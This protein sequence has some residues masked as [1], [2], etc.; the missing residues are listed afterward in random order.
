MVVRLVRCLIQTIDGQEGEAVNRSGHRL[1]AGRLREDNMKGVCMK[2]I[3]TLWVILFLGVQASVGGQPALKTGV[4]TLPGTLPKTEEKDAS[5]IGDLNLSKETFYISVPTGSSANKPHGILVFLS[6]V[7]EC[8]DVP[9]GWASVL[10]EK[11]LIFIAPQKAGNKQDTSR[12][13]GLAVLAATKLQEMAK[14]DTNRV[15]VAGFSGGARVASYCSFLRPSLFSGAFSVCGVDFPAQVPRVKATRNDEYGY[16]SLGE[17]EVAEA[18]QRVKFVLVTGSKDFRYG[19]IMDIYTGG[20]QK[21]G[22]TV[23]LIDVPGMDHTI[24]SPRALS[25]G[26]SFLDTKTRAVPS[27]K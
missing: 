1:T 24:C 16:F 13:A 9:P 23:K 20:F 7:D 12:R 6:P 18:K 26:I 27:G 11:K 15:Y 14:I 19:N 22:Y 25:D 10:K 4:Q 21:D 3:G 8:T 5:L 17:Q 2:A